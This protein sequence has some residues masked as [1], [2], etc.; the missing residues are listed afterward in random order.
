M[1]HEIASSF[2]R[3]LRDLPAIVGSHPGALER[4]PANRLLARGPRFRLDAETIRDS[5][6]AASGLL[7]RAVGGPPVFPYQPEGVW[8]Q[9]YY[10]DYQWVNSEGVD[11]YRRGIYTFWRRTAPYPSFVNFDAP[12]REF[13]AVRRI[14][15]NT[16]LQALT[17]LNDPSFFVAA[18]ALAARLID[19]QSRDPRDRAELGFRLCVSRRPGANELD[20]IVA[21]FTQQFA[22][23]KADPP[24]ARDLARERR[25]ETPPKSRRGLLSRTSC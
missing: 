1:E 17:T 3:H 25:L 22:R 2:D 20:Q 24:A 11:G 6:L 14:R 7:A 19:A 9:P 18:K 23:F 12:S 4:D 21:L 5:A 13:C 16:P 10:K 15:T 8:N